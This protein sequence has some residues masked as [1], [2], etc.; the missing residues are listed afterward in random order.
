MDFSFSAQEEAFRREVCE[1]L[2]RH[3]PHRRDD[4]A[5]A[6]EN[7]E[8][9]L[10]R[11]PKL[12]AWNQALYERGWVGF[13]WPK[14]VGG[15]GGGLVQQMILK[16]EA[17]KA[18]APMLGL[19]F[20]GLAWVGPAIIEYGT[21]EQ[22]QR[23]IPPILRAEEHWCTGYSEPGSGSDLASLQCR[24]ERSGDAYVINGQKIW[25]SLAQWAQWMILLVRTD[26]AASKHLGIT[27][28]LVPMNV[29]GITVRPIR[30]M[31]G[32]T[33]FAE[34]FFDNVRVPLGNRLGQEG[35]GW[36]V[37][38]TALAHERS[39]IAEVTG[40]QHDLE[41]LKQLAAD[42]SLNGHPA[43]ADPLIRQRLAR[44]ES[45]VEAMRLNGLRFLTRQLR[46]DPVGAETSINKLLRAQA[47]V[48]I[49]RLACDI[50][51][52]YGGLVRGSA[53][54]KEGGR[55]QHHMLSW[56]SVVIGG[57]TP[58]IQKNVIAERI[59]GLPHD[60]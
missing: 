18:R 27:C 28:L 19:S 2:A 39:S 51:G 33:P 31:N 55:W 48:E 20:M 7:I 45:T 11:L 5:P 17:G 53:G 47:E 22:K 3:N 41:D 54:V 44:L 40:L 1:F 49:G 10:E 16:E 56:P 8:A 43:L 35:Q 50:Q 32:D 34:V 14:E 60:G 23:F 42:C 25:T 37:T 30:T 24:A 26:P 36:Q 12:L 52:S 15:A 13:S 57:G 6:A 4:A 9:S 21:G 46:G 29:P 58:N 38:K 59:L